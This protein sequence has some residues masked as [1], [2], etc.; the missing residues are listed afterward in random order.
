MNHWESLISSVTCWL[1]CSSNNT[2]PAGG[3]LERNSS[4]VSGRHATQAAASG[5]LAEARAQSEPCQLPSNY[6][7]SMEIQ[8][9]VEQQHGDQPHSALEPWQRQT[10][11]LS[12]SRCYLAFSWIFAHYR[13]GASCLMVSRW[14]ALW[15]GTEQHAIHARCCVYYKW[16]SCSKRLLLLG[17]KMSSSL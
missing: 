14:R 17:K 6:P 11:L 2:G 9:Q 5:P 13:K 8:V 12:S 3:G 4:D 15:C 10:G 1:W 16:C 7:V